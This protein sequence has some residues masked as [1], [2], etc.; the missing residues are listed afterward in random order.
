MIATILVIGAVVAKRPRRALFKKLQLGISVLVL[1]LVPPVATAQ[2]SQEISAPYEGAAAGGISWGDAETGDFFVSAAGLTPSRSTSSIGFVTHHSIAA[3]AQSVEYTVRV[4]VATSEAWSYGPAVYTEVPRYDQA[5]NVYTGSSEAWSSGWV[6]GR[7]TMSN[8]PSCTGTGAAYIQWLPDAGSVNGIH[9]LTFVLQNDAGS[10]PA[11]DVDLYL[12]VDVAAQGDL[13]T[14]GQTE[15]VF[16]YS[17]RDVRSGVAM[18]ALNGTVL[19]ATARFV[20][21]QQDA[22]FALTTLATMPAQPTVGDSTTI[23]ASVSNQGNIGSEASKVL[24]LVD[25]IVLA[26]VPLSPMAVGASA[27][28]TSS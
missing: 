20:D 26:E 21:S 15:P 8:C 2:D 18:I 24:F 1:C 19:G 3:A 10:V 7:A 28:A 17:A 11:G 5:P 16:G 23:S 25:D 6:V 27:T 4:N 13:S 12:G 9:E 14:S 22:D